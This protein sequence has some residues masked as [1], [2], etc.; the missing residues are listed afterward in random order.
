M[1]Y[2]LNCDMNS[3]TKGAMAAVAVCAMM[4]ACSGG[5]NAG[6]DGEACVL[7]L[8]SSD[9][10]LTPADVMQ[11]EEWVSVDTV[12]G[13]I[14][15]AKKVEVYAGDY[16]ILDNVQQKCVMV[17]DKE[18]R[19]KRRI[20]AVGAGPG[21]YPSVSDFAIDEKNGEVLILTGSFQVFKYGIDG[22]F[23]RSFS[24]P[25]EPFVNIA[26]GDGH[27]WLS[28]NYVSTGECNLLYRY[29]TDFEADG[30]WVPYTAGGGAVGAFFSGNLQTVGDKVWYVDNMHLKMLEYD[31]DSNSF[32]E[33]YRFELPDPMTPEIM[34]D[35][36]AFMTRQRELDWL[37]QVSVLPHDM[38]VAYIASG[39]L[40]LSVYDGE[41]ELMKSGEMRGAVP[42][43]FPAGDDVIVSP[44]T[45]DEYTYVWANADVPKPAHTPTEDTNLLLMRWR[46][47]R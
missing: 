37:Y 8:D 45:V 32:E 1:F 30:S 4:A 13:Y 43:C 26:A 29:T 12:S 46:L 10:V 16:Y 21:E 25:T 15:N 11:V 20:G 24:S 40:F 22:T 31:N 36:S 33:R 39:K 41:G 2:Q 27:I 5:G 44:V 35:M 17:Y 38:L 14:G 23:V 9:A 6:A 3:S 7:R 42:R 47:R 19:F 28:T 34:A 18:G